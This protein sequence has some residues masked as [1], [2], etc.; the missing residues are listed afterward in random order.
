MTGNKMEVSLVRKPFG[1]DVNNF[2]PVLKIM[3]KINDKETEFI[4]ISLEQL[5]D[6]HSMMGKKKFKEELLKVFGLLND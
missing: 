5:Q 4:S 1:I 3:L 2:S 6:V